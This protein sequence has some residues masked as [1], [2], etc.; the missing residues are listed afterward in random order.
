MSELDKLKVST[1]KRPK[2]KRYLED[3]HFDF[4]AVDGGLGPHVAMTSG[5]GAASLDNNP[6][7]LKSIQSEKDTAIK[8]SVSSEFT[9]EQAEILK[10]IGEWKD[11][12]SII[13]N[14]SNN[15]TIK[16]EPCMESTKVI[17]TPAVVDNAVNEQVALLTKQMEELTKTNNIL[18]SKGLIKGF[19]FS[20]DIEKGV[21]EI[22]ATI[23]ADDRE[24][25]VKAFEVTLAKAVNEKVAVAKSATEAENPLKTLLEKEAGFESEDSKNEI[26]KDT[27]NKAVEKSLVE[28]LK[29]HLDARN[30][31]EVK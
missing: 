17:P 7:M 6:I 5:L 26:E 4:E 18:I 15:T 23:K 12:Y 14:Q 19:G 2:I 16:K 11:E 8:K 25:L 13:K 22:L 9:E 24:L 29:E 3:V 21:A 27:E 20:E 31:K 10:T 28:K 1:I 30:T